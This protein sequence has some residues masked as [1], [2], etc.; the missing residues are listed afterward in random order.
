[1][2]TPSMLKMMRP[3]NT[4]AKEPHTSLDSTTAVKIKITLA[5]MIPPESQMV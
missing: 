4:P 1:M 5:P 2:Y 3:K